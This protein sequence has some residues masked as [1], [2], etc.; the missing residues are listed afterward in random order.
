MTFNQTIE[1]QL[2]RSPGKEADKP[3]SF[4]RI[5]HPSVSDMC[6]IP[7]VLVLNR[8][9]NHII[10]FN[11]RFINVH[12][13]RRF[14]TFFENNKSLLVTFDDERSHDKWPTV[15]KTDFTKPHLNDTY[16]IRTSY[17]ANSVWPIR[18]KPGG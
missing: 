10:F 2:K 11:H 13:R 9:T 7:R 15:E 12:L 16:E 18:Y 1:I 3:K 5:L 6:T 4:Y 17:K 8:R 14:C